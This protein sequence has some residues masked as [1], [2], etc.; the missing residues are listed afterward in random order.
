LIDYHLHS[1]RSGDASGTIMDTC[2]RAVEVGLTEICFTEHLDFEP[3]DDCYGA[4]DYDLYTRQ[5]DEARDAFGGR[6]VVRRGI[7]VDYQEKHR[8]SIEDYLARAEFDYIVGSAHYVDGIILEDHGSYF[9][10]KSARQAYEPYFENV[11]ATIQT[12]WFDCVAHLDLCKR[13]GV[14][15]FGSFACEPYWEWI[16]G[17]LKTAIGMGMSIEINT[18]GLRQSPRDT[19]PCREILERYHALGGRSITVGSDSHRVE[20]VG[21]GIAEALEI[22]RSVGFE[23]ATTFAGRTPSQISIA[24]ARTGSEPTTDGSNR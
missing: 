11:I 14:R 2:A 15:Y 12:G 19:Y 4:F 20:D 9:P 5:I 24:T 16:D 6:L 18:S 22:A 1:E 13:Y 10:G 8:S 23:N 21:A 3:T 17:A 7:E